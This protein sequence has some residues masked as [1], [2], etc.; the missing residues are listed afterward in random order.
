MHV[1]KCCMHAHVLSYDMD[2]YTEE[3]YSVDFGVSEFA[4]VEYRKCFSSLKILSP[5]LPPSP[6]LPPSFLPLS[7]QEVAPSSQLAC[8]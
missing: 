5:P 6:L 4:S 3:F 7:L 8:G 2:K 1:N